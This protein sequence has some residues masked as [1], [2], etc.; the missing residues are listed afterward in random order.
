MGLNQGKPPVFGSTHPPPM[1]LFASFVKSFSAILL[2]FSVSSNALQYK[3]D[4]NCP[5][6]DFA[7]FVHN[8]YLYDRPVDKFTNITKSFFN[9]PWYGGADV[10]NTT[11]TDNV[12]GATRAG[13][14]DGEP[15]NE[16]LT[17]YEAGA[18][19]L[20]FTYFGLPAAYV[21]PN[22][23]HLRFSYY[24]ETHRYESI[25]EGTSTFIDQVTWWCSNAPRDSFDLWVRLHT[26]TFDNMA[27][28]VG[29]RV[30]TGDCP[31]TK[32]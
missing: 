28:T 21:L 27:T 24:A 4:I 26:V 9:I 1:H 10:M 30:F 22:G 8:S 12:P 31:R 25:C 29:A 18:G 15:F 19:A 5:K 2:Y 20:E 32:D 13:T 11:G 23:D 6:G 7:G 3:N 16:T 14:F 17:A